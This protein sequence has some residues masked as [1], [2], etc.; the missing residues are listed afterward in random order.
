MSY[1]ESGRPT[2]QDS[3]RTETTSN[4]GGLGLSNCDLK[5]S[6]AVGTSGYRIS[7]RGRTNDVSK[8]DQILNAEYLRISSH[9]DKMVDQLRNEARAMY[10]RQMNEAYGHKF[11]SSDK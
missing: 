3:F 7:C 2:S 11:D 1:R 6:I 9:F 10:A 5:N 8:L 4:P